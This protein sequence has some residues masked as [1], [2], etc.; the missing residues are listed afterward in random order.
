MSPTAK[1]CA[2]VLCAGLSPAIPAKDLVDQCVG[3]KWDELVAQAAIVLSR[4]YPEYGLSEKTAFECPSFSLT[5]IDAESLNAAEKRFVFANFM[6]W[7][8]YERAS[9]YLK[10][11]K[12]VRKAYRDHMGTVSKPKLEIFR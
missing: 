2:V 8:E 6:E 5:V 11:L 7:P 12:E 3:G 1:M 10:I 9:F 4:K